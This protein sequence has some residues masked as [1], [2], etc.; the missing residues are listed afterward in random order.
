[1]RVPSAIHPVDPFP[2]EPAFVSS[3]LANWPNQSTPLEDMKILGL[4]LGEV[5]LFNGL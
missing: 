2:L 1:M 4:F 5:M 3:C